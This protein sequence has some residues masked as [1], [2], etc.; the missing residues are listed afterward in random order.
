MAIALTISSYA[1]Q[2]PQFSDYKLNI[3]S[4]N[5]AFAG[6]YDGS[7]MLIHRSQFV[8]IE[9]APTA[10]NFN[11]NLPVNETMGLGMNIINQSLGVT[12]ETIVTGDYSYS[13]F[14]SDDTMLTFGLKAGVHVL[15]VDYSRLNIYDE[16]DIGFMNNI[17]GEISPRIGLGFLFSSPK[18]FAGLSTPNFLKKNYILKKQVNNLQDLNIVKT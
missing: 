15:S 12:D 5:P 17:K 10:I 4:F 1:Q 2:E 13:L 6:F 11:I 18:W 8:G 9:G 16:D 3:S 7:A 14:T